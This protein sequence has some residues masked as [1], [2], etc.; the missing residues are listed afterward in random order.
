MKFLYWLTVGALAMPF[1][2]SAQTA[3][4]E[5]FEVNVSSGWVPLRISSTFENY[6]NLSLKRESSKEVPLIL[7]VGYTQAFNDRY[8]VGVSINHDLFAS[9]AVN[10]NVYSNGNLVNSAG[11]T[12]WLDNRDGGTLRLGRVMDESNLGYVRVGQAWASQFGTNNNGSV[13]NSVRFKYMIYGVGVKHLISPKL[14]ALAEIDYVNMVPIKTLRTVGNTP[15]T[16]DSRAQG[17]WLVMGVGY[18]F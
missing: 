12:Q 17:N 8:T 13:F 9:R 4:F 16:V 2:G 10:A 3:A 1:H 11:S 7:S 18:Q 6:P 5:G 15:M 14:Y